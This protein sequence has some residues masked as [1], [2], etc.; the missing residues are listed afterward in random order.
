MD[1]KAVLKPSCNLKYC[2][3]LAHRIP[4]TIIDTTY[5][6]FKKKNEDR[7]NLIK[8]ITVINSKYELVT[9]PSFNFLMFPVGSSEKETEF[10]K[11]YEELEKVKAE[12][13]PQF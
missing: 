6:Y 1:F 13:E 8:Y 11:Y 9:M 5:E 12:E 4:Y 7:A 10:K 2:F 3:G